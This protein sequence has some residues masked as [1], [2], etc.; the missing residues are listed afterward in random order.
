[1]MLS[2]VSWEPKD[3]E[4]TRGIRKGEESGEEKRKESL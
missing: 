3:G 1:M 2:V 4:E